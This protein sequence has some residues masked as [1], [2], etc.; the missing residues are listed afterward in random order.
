MSPCKLCF[1]AVPD[2]AHLAKK[3]WGLCVEH[4]E[5]VILENTMLKEQLSSMLSYQVMKSFISSFK[6]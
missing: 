4:A 1:L 3:D 6:G 5:E 2:L